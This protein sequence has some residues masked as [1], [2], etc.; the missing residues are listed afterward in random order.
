MAD[1]VHACTVGELLSAYLDAELSNS[2]L[3]A[4][5]SHLDTCLDCIAEFH[6]LREARTMLRTMPRLEVPDRALPDIHYK[7][8]L[9]AYLD[10]ELP[11]AE[12]PV[13]FAHM[14]LCA[15]CRNELYEMDGARIAI[16]A[17]PRLDPVLHQATDG[18]VGVVVPISRRRMS[19]LAA[20]AAAAAFVAFVS[21]STSSPQGP[22]V[23]LDSFLVQH[24]ARDS[25]QSPLSL[26]P[27]EAT[28]VSVS[29]P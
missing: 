16:R 12:Q 15:E 5:V 29:S 23:N 19:W 24:G 28:F 25:V 26:L 21:F 6:E 10:G 13:V 18:D 4:V 22:T 8:E 3:E 20:G 2:E 27:S 17:L 9:S 11:T 7:V 14:V 1:V